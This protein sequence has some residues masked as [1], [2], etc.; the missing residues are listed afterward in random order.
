MTSQ[1]NNGVFKQTHSF[2]SSSR[3]RLHPNIAA[4][5]WAGLRQG[6]EGRQLSSVTMGA[7]EHRKSQV[8]MGKG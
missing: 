6:E 2:Q 7:F 8:K 3:S 5:C 1:R 4:V